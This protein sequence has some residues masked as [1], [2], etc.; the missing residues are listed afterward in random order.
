MATRERTERYTRAMASVRSMR[1][2]SA[3]AA[4]DDT[5]TMVTFS[6]QNDGGRCRGF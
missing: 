2:G 1:A 5:G 4:V 3:S 6:A